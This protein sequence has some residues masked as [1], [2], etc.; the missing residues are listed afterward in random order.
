MFH[1][2][3]NIYKKVYPS[4]E[5]NFY[6][7][8]SLLP[9][10]NYIFLTKEQIGGLFG[11]L[12][13]LPEGYDLDIVRSMF[14]YRKFVPRTEK[15]VLNLQHAIKNNAYIIREEILNKDVEKYIDYSIRYI[16]RYYFNCCNKI[17]QAPNREY[18]SKELDDIPMCGICK[19]TVPFYE[20]NDDE[21]SLYME[22]NG[23]CKVDINDY[24]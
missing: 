24:I 7:R 16:V 18:T 21:F 9:R 23:F 5:R 14:K 22:L 1:E 13:R 10:Q 2:L 19:S 6:F 4:E 8:K 11:I 17:L 12:V 3:R 15:N 20:M